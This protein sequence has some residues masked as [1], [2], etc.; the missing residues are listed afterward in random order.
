MA[1]RKLVPLTVVMAL[2]LAACQEYSPEAITAS[3]PQNSLLSPG[4]SFNKAAD[5]PTTGNQMVVFKQERVPADF[6]A[7]VEALG[8]KVELAVDAF[9][10]AVISGVDD[11][12]LAALPGVALVEPEALFPMPELTMVPDVTMVAEAAMP[13]SPSNPTLASFWRRQWGMR[14]IEADRAWAAG[15]LGDSDVTVA[16]LDTGIGYTHPD[17]VGLV[18]LSRSISFIPQ[19]D[20]YVRLVFPGA[21]LVADIHYHGTHV[22]ATVSSNGIAAAGVTSKTTLMGVKVCSAV[23]GGC[24]GGAIFAGVEHAVNNGAH[25]INMSLGGAFLKSANPGYISVINRVFNYANKNDVMVVA[26][27]GNEAIDLDHDLIPDEDDE[28]IIYHYPSLYKTYCSTPHNFCV[29]ATGPTGLYS[30]DG[31][32]TNVDSLA[33]YSNYGRSAINVAA[34]GGNGGGYVTAA[35]SPFSLISGLTVCQTGTYV[36][37]I[38]GTSMASPHVA[39]LAAM[40]MSKYGKKASQT[41]N[42]IDNYADDLGQP[43]TDP[44]YGKGRI[45]VYR[46]MTGK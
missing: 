14:A 26:S 20:Q 9:G 27:A 38:A 43:G 21:H 44:A 23:S 18:D 4:A 3:G 15:Y 17:L 28:T 11:A 30:A 32:W 41:R 46:T 37:A 8:G 19:D 40:V 10:V 34:P 12:T 6:A 31:P 45:N 16:I 33:S 7:R 2:G 1:F 22:A 36:V 29:S 24:P 35:C 39:G 13:A 25:I 5:L 42:R